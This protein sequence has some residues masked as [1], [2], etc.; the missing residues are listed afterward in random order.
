M[1]PGSGADRAGIRPGDVI[2]GID[3]TFLDTNTGA[4]ELLNRHAIGDTVPY[5]VRSGGHIFE[6]EVE[7]G[8]RT[9]GDVAYL[10][11]CLLGLTFFLVG[12]FVV[13]RQPRMPAARV[14]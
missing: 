1:V 7:M 8:R 11:A 14:W 2:V 10:A 9:I 5:L 12:S 4:Q 3:R 6:V 13:I